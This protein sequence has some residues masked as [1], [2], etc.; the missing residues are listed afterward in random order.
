MVENGYFYPLVL[1]SY[2]KW[3]SI[4]WVLP[5]KIVISI[6]FDIATEYMESTVESNVASAVSNHVVTY[7]IIFEFRIIY[8]WSHVCQESNQLRYMC[9][10][11]HFGAKTGGET[12]K[13]RMQT[14]QRSSLWSK[15]NINFHT[16][17][18][19]GEAATTTAWVSHDVQAVKT[20]RKWPCWVLELY[21]TDQTCLVTLTLTL[22]LLSTSILQLRSP[23]PE[24]SPWY[25]RLIRSK[26]NYHNIWEL[27]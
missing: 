21:G 19:K 9:I 7:M 17:V 16:R 27:I 15:I 20:S 23:A 25:F 6:L 11:I 4:Q 26:M 18:K 2:W 22:S 24:Y 3:P 14:S 12:T 5:L 8:T 1:T 10:H 13:L